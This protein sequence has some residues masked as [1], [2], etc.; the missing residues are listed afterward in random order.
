MEPEES[1]NLPDDLAEKLN[2]E[3]EKFKQMFNV[4]EESALV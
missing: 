3:I 4:E 2:T 1:L